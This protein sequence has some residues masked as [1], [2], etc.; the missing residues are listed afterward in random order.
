M[1]AA[2]EAGA[3]N[4][5]RAAAAA[6]AGDEDPAATEPPV[7]AAEG[8]ASEEESHSGGDTDE[9]SE[10]ESSDSEESD[11][12]RGAEQDDCNDDDEHPDLLGFHSDDELYAGAVDG[13]EEGDGGD[14]DAWLDLLEFDGP[15]QPEAIPLHADLVDLYNGASVPAPAGAASDFVDVQALAGGSVAETAGLQTGIASTGTTSAPAAV[16]AMLPPPI[17]QSD[18]FSSLASALVEVEPFSSAT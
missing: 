11:G 8:G 5:S 14:D 15:E 3:A 7:D 10:G 17:S 18:P 6:A 12:P 1:S 2:P 16:Q 13:G 4:V 9:D